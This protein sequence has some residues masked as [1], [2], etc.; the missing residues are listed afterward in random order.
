MSTTYE[1][2]RLRKGVSTLLTSEPQLEIYR[3]W[4]THM[5][6]SFSFKAQYSSKIEYEVLTV[7]TLNKKILKFIPTVFSQL[8]VVSW[9]LICDICG[10]T[11]WFLLKCNSKWISKTGSQ[12]EPKWF[13]RKV[14]TC[15][16]ICLLSWIDA[17]FIWNSTHWGD[18]IKI[19]SMGEHIFDQCSS[20]FT[21]KAKHNTDIYPTCLMISQLLS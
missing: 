14:S 6:G 11:S 7:L 9:H 12:V 18:L 3:Y 15:T 13:L 10:E 4:R 20:G 2:T 17:H 8:E 19:S 16:W 5:Q 21:T 1:G